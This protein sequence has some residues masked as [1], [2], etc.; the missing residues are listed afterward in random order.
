MGEEA[1]DVCWTV[2][3]IDKG[4]IGLSCVRGCVVCVWGSEREN[5]NGATGEERE[6]T[7]SEGLSGGAS[8]AV[9]SSFTFFGTVPAPSTDPSPELLSSSEFSSVCLFSVLL[10]VSLFNRLCLTF[11]S[12]LNKV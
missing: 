9:F 5:G 8:R 12:L 6:E 1:T 3:V 4:Y 2:L 7:G 11:L 10:S